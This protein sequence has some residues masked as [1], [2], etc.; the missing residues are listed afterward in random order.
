MKKAVNVERGTFQLMCSIENPKPR[1]RSN[2]WYHA[3]GWQAG[4][5]FIIEDYPIGRGE[6]IPYLRRAQEH[7][8]VAPGH[9]LF[10]LVVNN[11]EAINEEPS[12]FLNRVGWVNLAPKILDRLFRANVITLDDVKAQMENELD[13]YDDLAT[14]PGEGG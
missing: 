4:A 13:I 1:K 10:W 5:R 7:D 12:D 14:P 3:E 8:G 6:T 11:L 9:P 2:K